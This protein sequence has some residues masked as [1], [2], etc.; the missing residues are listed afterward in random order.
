MKTV[1]LYSVSTKKALR[2]QVNLSPKSASLLHDMLHTDT[3]SHNDD[4]RR[5]A[6]Y[7][8]AKLVT[9]LERAE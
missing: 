3:Q 5:L 8:Q 4:V 6:V 1:K 2:L 7:L 9:L